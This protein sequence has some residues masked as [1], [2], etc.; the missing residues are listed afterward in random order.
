MQNV[1]VFCFLISLQ[2]EPEQFF[3]AAASPAIPP[4]TPVQTSYIERPQP[5]QLVVSER[6]MVTAAPLPPAPAKQAK[7]EPAPA[8]KK[9]KVKVA[10]PKPLALRQDTGLDNEQERK[11]AVVLAKVTE[12]LNSGV[13]ANQFKAIAVLLDIVKDGTN[14]FCQCR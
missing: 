5:E 7:Q 6:P 3:P 2:T 4:S 14:K 12:M 11:L 1:L 13:P 10:K 8:P 9:E